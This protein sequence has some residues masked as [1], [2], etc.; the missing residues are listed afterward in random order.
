MAEG[1]R[2]CPVRHAGALDSRLRRWLQNPERLLR[3]FLREGMKVLEFG[4]GPGFFSAD[5]ARLVGPAGR[6]VAADLQP[7]MLDRLRAKIA[8]TEFEARITL[9]RCEPAAIGL[10]ENVDFVLAFYVLHELPDQDAFFREVR[11]LLNPAGRVLVVEPPLHVSRRAFAATLDAAA[12]AGFVVE[13][14][15]RIGWNKAA[16]LRPTTP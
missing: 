10:S 1:H 2:V 8:G 13:E 11:T 5:I 12:R 9:H 14:R 4:C 15:P 16:L 3:P 7:E 6:L